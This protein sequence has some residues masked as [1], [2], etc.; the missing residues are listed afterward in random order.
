MSA[1]N[2]C[3]GCGYESV[4]EN[5]NHIYMVLWSDLKIKFFE[6][7]AA[8]MDRLTTAN[9]THDVFTRGFAA[10]MQIDHIEGSENA[11]KLW[12]PDMLYEHFTTHSKEQ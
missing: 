3:F 1:P 2:C 5:P 9:E 8:N 11:I 4:G 10:Q 7:V 6:C 12:A